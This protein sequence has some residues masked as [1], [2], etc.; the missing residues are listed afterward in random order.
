MQLLTF[1]AKC[2]RA[3][4][5]WLIM[6]RSLKRETYITGES[7]IDTFYATLMSL[8]DD[9]AERASL[10]QAYEKQVGHS[11][12]PSGIFDSAAGWLRITRSGTASRTSH[13]LG[14][15][16]AAN[17]WS[18]RMEGGC[19][20]PELRILDSGRRCKERG[21]GGAFEGWTGAVCSETE[22]GVV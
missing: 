3:R 17:S 15:L 16:V 22:G 9:G 12:G 21:F 19:S 8:W 6:M 20:L 11:A 14:S 18:A 5:D 7:M 2:L 13:L 4:M 10:R 1:P